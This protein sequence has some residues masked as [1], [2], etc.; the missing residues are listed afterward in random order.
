MK[1]HMPA[2][3]VTTVH[4]IACIGG[5][6]GDPVPLHNNTRSQIQVA[7]VNDNKTSGSRS[8]LTTDVIDN[9]QKWLDDTVE[10][11]DRIVG[12]SAF[13][14]AGTG[15]GVTTVTSGRS[16]LPSAWDATDKRGVESGAKE[17]TDETTVMLASVSKLLTWTALIMLMDSGKF[18]IDDP[19]ND[20]LPFDVMN[21]RFQNVAITYR[22]LFAHT[23]GIKDSW[24]GYLYGSDCPNDP[25]NPY[26][27][28]LSE[29]IKEK[30]KG[31][32][33]WTNN[34]PGSKYTYS[35]YGCALGALLVERHSGFS[36]SDFT[37][38]FIFD[39]LQMTSTRWSRPS[40]GSAAELYTLYNN[41]GYKYKT[42]S[43]GYCFPDYPSG[44]LW[45]TPTDLAKFGTA[46]LRRGNLGYTTSNGANCLYSETTG[47]L[48]FKKISPNTGDGD[49]ALGWFVGPPYYKGGA[50]HD[51]GETGVSA[52]QSTY[53]AWEGNMGS[54]SCCA[55]SM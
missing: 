7:I 28:T 11:A 43:G 46:M 44:Q 39:P 9:L 29:I 13:L 25:M 20:A 24:D 42:N 33:K 16:V 21:P 8:T 14:A 15:N 5:C 40:D 22:H 36:F 52:G 48:V 19:I 4:S 47:D 2:S 10:S 12:V 27:A 31:N 35:N 50:G 17:I 37:K 55:F 18:G 6:G 45:S 53:A 54:R 23:S 41:K 32:S 26:P 1:F 3:L 34:K 49:S 38:K 30:T 51:G